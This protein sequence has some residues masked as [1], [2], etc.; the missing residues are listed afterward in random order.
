MNDLLAEANSVL[1]E[2]RRLRDQNKLLR[3]HAAR[4]SKEIGAKLQ[5]APFHRPS[6]LEESDLAG[7][8]SPAGND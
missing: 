3:Q 4:L 6:S 7:L 5:S 8:I 1:R 2:T